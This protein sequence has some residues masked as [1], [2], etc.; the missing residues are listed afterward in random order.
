MIP[1][2]VDPSWQKWLIPEIK[3][4]YMKELEKFLIQ[5]ENLGK[6]IYPPQHEIFSAL[7]MT[8]LHKVKVVILGQ[9]PYHGKGQAHG[10]CFSVKSGVQLPPSLIN[11]FKELKEDLGILPPPHGNLS[12]WAL[13]G[14]LLLNN[15]LTVEEGKPEG[16]YLKGWEEFTDTIINILNDQRENLVFIL[17]GNHAQKKAAKVDCKKHCLLKSAHPS[18]LS[19]YRGFFGSRPFSQTN[20]FLSSKGLSPINWNL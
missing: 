17:W 18:P 8:P 4:P 6:N 11:I 20:A 1:H 15:V 5:E 13:Q 14:V 7:D 3:K 16:H 12:N 19:S 10:L 2:P 9:D